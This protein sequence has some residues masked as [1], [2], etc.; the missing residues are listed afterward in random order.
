MKHLLL[1]VILLVILLT[2]MNSNLFGQL[3][4]PD[5]KGRDFWLTF[6]PNIHRG[7]VD[8]NEAIINSDSLH[9]FIVSE[10][11]T[12]GV[13]TYKDIF[14]QVYTHNFSI[15]DPSKIHQFSLV[16]RNF[17]LVG[18]N[19][20]TDID[21]ENG[22]NEK[23]AKQSFNITSKEEITVYAINQAITTSDAF[24]VLPVD[25]L[26][27][28]YF[29]MSYNSDGSFRNNFNPPLDNASTPSQFAVVATEDNTTITIR[30]TVAT[31]RNNLNVQSVNLSRGDVYLVQANMLSNLRADLTGTQVVSNKP[32][33]VFS[34][35]QRATVPVNIGNLTSRDILIEQIPPLST[36]GFSAFITPYPIPSTITESGNDIYRVLAGYDN[37]IVTVDKFQVALLDKG[38]F[39][40]APIPNSAKLVEANNPVLVAQFKQTSGSGNFSIQ[41][42]DPFMMLIPPAE[43]FMKS[44]RFINVQVGEN[45][46]E[47][48]SI[49]PVPNVY[50]EQYV[51]IVSPTLY[52]DRVRFDGGQMNA[53]EFT[54]I[55]N[56]T[57][58]YVNKR[59][60]GGV[61]TVD[62]D[63]I[64]G[65][66]VYGY[67]R[68]NSYG[69]VGGMNFKKIDFRAPQIFSEN[70]CGTFTGTILDTGD[71][72]TKIDQ[73]F[74][75]QDSI[76]NVTVNYN[77]VKADSS[78]FSGRLINPY[79][80]GKFTIIATDSSRLR[81]R[82]SF[83]VPGFTLHTSVTAT[84]PPKEIVERIVITKRY[85]FEVTI[86]NYGKF[87]QKIDGIGFKNSSPEFSFLN[88][89]LP[90]SIAPGKS[91]NITICFQGFSEKEVIDSLIILNKC[92]NRTV[93][94]F[95][96]LV[97]VDN[98][99]PRINKVD[100]Q[101]DTTY[102]IQLD[103][104]TPADIGLEYVRILDS[105]LV[106]AT[107]EIISDDLPNSIK[108]RVK[109][110]DIQK[111]A[112]VGFEA[113][114]SASNV[115]VRIDT[116]KGYTLAFTGK[117][118]VHS[119]NYGKRTISTMFCDTL[120]FLNEGN[121]PIEF[122]YIHLKHNILYS[123][124]Q[125]Q[126]PFI[127][128]PSQQRSL[129][130]CFAPLEENPRFI[131]EW[132]DSLLFGFRCYSHVIPL[133]G[134][135][136][137]YIQSSNT[138]CDVPLIVTTQKF[139]IQTEIKSFPN[140]PSGSNVT[141][142]FSLSS[143][144]NVSISLSNM[145]GEIIS[146]PIEGELKAGEYMFQLP[147]SKLSKG[148]YFLQL[149]TTKQKVGTIISIV[150]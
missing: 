127:I 8:R 57:Y 35:H 87:P 18:L 43:Q 70:D 19:V 142:E 117:D 150:Q 145:L 82:K 3:E 13:I 116:I 126:F 44:Y 147:T 77:F 22:Q 54:Q 83:D 38:E 148:L 12:T 140:P 58:S 97:R 135:G 23:I 60:S 96:I 121:Y 118:T 114:D 74:F 102:T 10:K 47:N 88:S 89:T 36:W 143:F 30:P 37:T 52:L 123:I 45:S 149:S 86:F 85:C 98:I 7:L 14:N 53:A 27:N 41:I 79:I 75:D 59:V 46:I 42:G 129:I 139:P 24:L 131:P 61:H 17:E 64:C 55:T 95:K 138:R 29:I 9:I 50:V 108:F 110:I 51:T 113:M 4:G 31:A 84:D 78:V 73:V 67:G 115:T 124:P 26:D 20:T 99:P 105:L 144:D 81:N 111:D 72:D 104:D 112:I 132:T 33:A 40:E 133:R 125:Y 25:I 92:I 76:K 56:T 11:A 101:C 68:A 103:D 5:S 16:F 49:I 28:E 69:Y 119:I 90:D 128:E 130:I 71:A 93:A 34:G 109:L 80:D 63:T 146:I 66:Y 62:S 48:G 91:V 65:I 141:V 107:V 134:I 2:T 136:E 100:N 106:N 39:F 120:Y 1:L 21:F 6:M 122:D 137:S 94:G 32:I 15:P